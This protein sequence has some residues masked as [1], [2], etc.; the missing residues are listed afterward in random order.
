MTRLASLFF[1]A[2]VAATGAAFLVT[3]RLKQSPRLVRTLTVT[4]A[5]SPNHPAV[6]ANI[7]IRL[8]RA[9]R[10]TVSIVDADGDRVR[11][12]LADSLITPDQKVW[13]IWNGHDDRNRVVPDG[14]YRVRVT[15][16]RQGRS[17]I[18]LD[19]IRVDG[20][21]PHPVVRVVRTPGATGP[22][23]LPQRGDAPVRFRVLGTRLRTERLF[24]Y[25]TDGPR[26]QFVQRLPLRSA[27]DAEGVWD[28][29]VH[30]RPAPPGVYTIAAKDTDDVRNFAISFPFSRPRRGD[31][32]GGAGVTV[33][34]LAAQSPVVPTP[35]GRTFKVYVDARGRPYRWRLHRLGQTRAISHGTRRSPVLPLHAPRGQS[36]VYVVDLAT[37]PHRYVALV[38]VQGPGRHRGMVMLSTI[39]WQG[40]APV[41]DDGD[42]QVDNLERP[43][44]RADVE[45]PLAGLGLPLGFRA[46]E[47]PLLWLLDRPQQ[48]YDITTDVALSTPRGERDLRAH[49][50]IVLA[51]RPR[52][53]TPRLAASLQRFVAGGGR[54]FSPG[55]DS[56]RRT[57]TLDHGT[58]RRPSGDTSSDIFGATLSPIT[59]R[60]VELLAG[61]DRIGLFRGGDG[62]FRGFNAFEE[63]LA[64]GPGA[65][66]V[67]AAEEQG[68][69]AGAPV[70]VAVA[71]KDGLVIRTGLP[72][73]GSR[74]RRD[75]N[76]AALTNRA[77]TLVSR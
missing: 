48:R 53:L 77:W 43:G 4:P 22:L 75:A 55:A 1:A 61:K 10:A 42:G 2:L 11:R 12:L 64:A 63:T 26:P 70:I 5:I 23:I 20:T 67:S 41:D 76:V 54:V 72:Q 34:Y 16:R 15:L 74:I 52:W 73:W 28:G 8:E 24:L 58:L 68:V 21:P 25:R 31:P 59:R 32:S 50:G 29:R 62:L 19:T 7:R 18:L 47:E 9:D 69:H 14:E 60:P 35:V 71:V 30:G 44:G 3:Q 27:Q 33:R 38:P 49:R 65:R 56:L 37:G 13:L 57:V 46:N 45:R 40:R 51:G 36:G 17:V 66:V 39:S 6:K